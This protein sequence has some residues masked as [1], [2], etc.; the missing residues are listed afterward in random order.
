MSYEGSCHCGAVTFTAD[1]DVPSRAV[2]CNCTHCRRKGLLLVF[3]LRD[4][5]R[6]TAW[7]DSLREYTFNTCNI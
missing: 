7:A 3:L 5:V 4:E 2:S 1:A 6:I